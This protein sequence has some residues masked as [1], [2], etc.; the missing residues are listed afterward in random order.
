M[1]PS[2]MRLAQSFRNLSCVA[3]I[4]A[5]LVTSPSFAADNRSDWP[6]AVKRE[7]ELVDLLK[8]EEFA[9]LEKQI[10][11]SAGKPKGG[12]VGEP[13]TD[14]FGAFLRAEP[15]LAGPLARW[16]DAYPRS[17]A[18]YL[19]FGLYG[20]AVGWK[21]RGE[22]IAYLTNRKRFE[23]MGT[24]FDAAEDSLKNALKIN[25]HLDAAWETLIDLAKARGKKIEMVSYLNRAIENLSK[26]SNAYR[27]YF[28]AIAPKW[29]GSPQERIE[30]KIRIM[31]KYPNDPAFAWVDDEEEF[32]K[33]WK[34][35]DD[36]HYAEALEKFK[37]LAA[38]RET[39]AAHLGIAWSLVTMR[40][41]A[42]GI[43]E[44]EKA[45]SMAPTNAS[46]YEQRSRMRRAIPEMR[47]EARRDLEIALA[48]DPYD[49]R[50]LAARARHLL[51]DGKYD[52]AKRDLD[53]AL[54]FGAYD[55]K[56]R[57]AWRNYYMRIGDPEAALKEAEMMVTLVPGNL[58]NHLM[59]GVML[60]ENEDC[61]GVPVLQ[62]Y[63]KACKISKSCD[64]RDKG[65]AEMTLLQ[66]GFGCN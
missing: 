64:E 25:P 52:G 5:A 45:I 35:Y 53:R 55:D 2:M 49:P 8:A 6:D 38:A 46:L 42:D 43:A 59:Y 9:D 16:R 27:H 24:Y 33:A 20:T 63:L 3:A 30:L 34:L 21:I 1:E 56:V 36:D 58:R 11:A 12:A 48:L 19:A 51:D 65:R 26:P 22:E 47:A 18:P 41:T 32:E 40:K 15:E 7:L 31:L 14:I 66:L 29:H 37:A 28:W 4:A 17:F 54:F 50:Y 57:D 44:M 39:S 10:A 60:H 13:N 61:R 62:Q 23:E